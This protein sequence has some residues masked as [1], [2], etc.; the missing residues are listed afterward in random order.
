MI[1]AALSRAG[2]V[3][4]AWILS[5]VALGLGASSRA[6]PQFLEPP[7][8][9][10]EGEDWEADP[11]DSLA[12]GVVEMGFG[13]AGREGGR[14]ARRRRLRYEGDDVSAALREGSG[15]PLSG[16]A[17]EG[18]GG[19]GTMTVGRL[20][21]LWGRG[22]LLGS[23]AEPWR[24]VP[25]DR[26]PRAA[27]RGRAGDGVALTRGGAGGLDALCGRFARRDLGGMRARWGGIGIGALADRDGS[28]QSSLAYASGV[29]EFE[30]AADGR[31]RWRAEALA[32][33]PMGGEWLASTRVRGGLDGFRSLAEPNRSGP[34]RALSVALLGPVPSG[35]IE[36]LAALWRFAPGRAGARA[37]LSLQARAGDGSSLELGLGESHGTLRSDSA[38]PGGFRQGGWAQW[39]SPPGLLALALRHETWGRA[40]FAREATRS[41]SSLGIEARGPLG[42]TVRASHSVYRVGSGES[43]YLP[44]LAPD[45]LVLRALSGDGE[46]TRLEA[47]VPVSGGRIAATVDLMRPNHRD[48]DVRWTFEWSRRS[49]A[50]GARR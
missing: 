3:R 9:A 2:R 16:G 17:V 43:L 37:W 4:A 6:H 41:V 19:A 47:R 31:G 50:G 8:E 30:L 1:R 21:P 45:R 10:P 29:T 36:A 32:N 40:A 20:A 46:R 24:R 42:V 13:A 35:R 15:D 11:A 26:G 34:S 48:R 12:D 18:R 33:R 5:I 14:P 27:Y 49:R 25:L 7:P 28:V 38:R 44:E 22:L 39:T 23:A